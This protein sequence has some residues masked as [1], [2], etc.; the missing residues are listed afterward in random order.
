MGGGG[1]SNRTNLTEEMIAHKSS[2][3]RK[4]QTHNRAVYWK[5]SENSPPSQPPLGNG[6]CPP[7]LLQLCSEDLTSLL[8][9]LP[10]STPDSLPKPA[11]LPTT[12]LPRPRSAAVPLTTLSLFVRASS[13]VALLFCLHHHR[14]G[15][16]RGSPGGQEGAGPATGSR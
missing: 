9:R 3:E 7:A 4:L 14:Q 2:A 13:P 12:M 8:L 1:V 5:Q 16:R 11:P 10:L 6:R 15:A